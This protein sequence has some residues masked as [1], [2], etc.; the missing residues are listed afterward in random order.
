M[1][2]KTV[3]DQNATK[4]LRTAPSSLSDFTARPLVFDACGEQL[5]RRSVLDLG[6]GEGYCARELKRRGAG[7]YLGVDLSDEMIQIAQ[8]QEQQDQYGIEYVSCDVTNFKPEGQ[9]DLCIAVFLFNYL[10]VEDM[11]QVMATAYDAI[12]PGGHFIF[13]VPHPF[14]PFV[15]QEEAPPFYFSSSGKNYFADVNQQFE[16]KIWKKGGEA[17]HVQ[18]VHKTFDDYFRGLRQAGFNTMPE[19]QELTVTTEL[20]QTDPEFFSPLINQPLHLLFKVSR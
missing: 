13:S 2:T 17:L 7:A 1:D 4:W 12:T 8:Q 15:R 18:C 16:G 10:S 11:H 5:E 19:L 9:F 14:F 20:A 3:Y 6:C